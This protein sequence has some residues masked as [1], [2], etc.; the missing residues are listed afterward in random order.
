MSGRNVLLI[1]K[2]SVLLIGFYTGLG[3]RST[4]SLDPIRPTH[5]L[6][7]PRS[8]HRPDPALD[9]KKGA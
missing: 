4:V 7:I 8:P 2:D 9:K 5:W 6:D 1:D 3:W